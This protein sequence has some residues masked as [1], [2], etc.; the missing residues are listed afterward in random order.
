VAWDLPSRQGSAS[1]PIGA[2]EAYDLARR[3]LLFRKR[4]ALVRFG[5]TLAATSSTIRA[6]EVSAIKA[7]GDTDQHLVEI[8][9]AIAVTVFTNVCN[10]INGTAIDVPAV[11]STATNWWARAGKEGSHEVAHQHL[12]EVWSAHRGP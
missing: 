7:A 10:R 8:S 5:R 11:A 4:D 1:P 3:R 9:L 2:L 6:E 12:N